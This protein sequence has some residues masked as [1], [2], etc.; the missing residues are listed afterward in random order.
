[1]S[2]N[3]KG[4]VLAASGRPFVV[5]GVNYDHDSK[6][7]LLEDYWDDEW[8][9]VEAAFAGAK[10]LGANVIRIHLQLAKFMDAPDRPNRRSLDR[11]GRLVALAGRLGLYLDVTGLGCYHKPD[12]PA[13]YDALDE[14]GRWEVQA[15]FWEAVAGRCARSPAVFCYDLMNEPIVPGAEQPQDNWLGPPFAGSCFVQFITREKK[16][17]LREEIARAWIH[18]LATAIRKRDRRHLI[19]VGLVPWSLDRPG[20]TSGFLPD[21]VAGDLDFL[22][23]H[24]YPEKGKG[25]DSLGVLKAF[26]GDKP[27]LVEEMFPLNCSAEE[28]LAFVDRSRGIAAGWISFYWGEDPEQCEASGTVSG[29]MIAA[30]LRAF[31]RKGAEIH[32]SA[33]RQ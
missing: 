11:L 31:R 17:R 20:I 26:S 21:K 25:D 9:A 5:W 27:V 12:V 16:G 10:R 18:R 15:R 28:L 1:M 6:G 8:P 24:L 14:T 7:R 4:F 23:V 32:P 22:A 30:W 13:W 3:G 2:P 29:A 19:T 33:A